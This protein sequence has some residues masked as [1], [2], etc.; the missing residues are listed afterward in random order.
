MA[1][2]NNP[3]VA[4]L[5]RFLQSVLIGDSDLEAFCLDYFPAVR[6]RFSSGMDR[7]QKLNIL[8]AAEAP[9]EILRRLYDTEPTRSARYAS[10]LQ[11]DSD[12]VET[13]GAKASTLAPAADASV[14]PRVYSREA[15]FDLLCGIPAPLFEIVVFRLNL[16]SATLA[17]RTSPQSER[18]LQV[19]ELLEFEGT[20]GLER[21][22]SALARTAPN[23]LK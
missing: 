8:L 12:M 9:Q 13:A 7:M 14:A 6:N 20:M 3:S 16:K 19:I 23:L 2:V 21:L 18:A 15:L 1:N 5:R 22:T 10:L 4:A 17:P 11:V